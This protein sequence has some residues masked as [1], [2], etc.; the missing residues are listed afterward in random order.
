LLISIVLAVD[1]IRLTK[2]GIMENIFHV[3]HLKNRA[4][5]DQPSAFSK[6]ITWCNGQEKYRFG[7]LGAI[8]AAQCCALTPI[9]LFAIV[10]FGANFALFMAA[11]VAIALP[12]VTNLAA[13]PTRITIP[14][15]FLS[16]VM[17]LAIIVLCLAS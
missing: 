5:A 7:W 9:T 16:I 11:L 14:V 3:R 13:M 4:E 6:F 2:S 8:M 15:F 1:E 17:D 10:L 12:V